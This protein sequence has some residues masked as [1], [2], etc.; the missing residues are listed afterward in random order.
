MNREDEKFADSAKALFDESVEKL[1][2]ATLSTL[3]RNRH[4]ALAQAR[5]AKARWTRWA[6]AMGLAAAVVL[7]VVL[8]M[9]GGGVDPMPADTT[10]VDILLGEESIE[11]LEDLEFYVWLDMQENDVG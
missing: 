6:P 10:D 1:D 8:V 4:A 11:M 3:N 5:G 9:P 2:A 7:A